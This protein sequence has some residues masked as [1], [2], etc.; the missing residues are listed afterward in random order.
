MENAIAGS[1]MR[2]AE[3]T[4]LLLLDEDTGYLIPL[5]EWKLACVLSGAVL[6]DLALENRIDTDLEKLVLIDGSHTGDELLDPFLGDIVFE[7][8]ARSPQYWVE[9]LAPRAEEIYEKTLERLAEKGILNFES[10]GFWTLA[11]KVGASG[12]YPV[13]EGAG[14]EEIKTRVTRILL[15]EDEIPDPRDVMIIG[16]VR[17]CGG[18][19]HFLDAEELE[20]VQERADLIK[21][22]D[23]I[24]QSISQAVDSIYKPPASLRVASRRPLPEMT[25]MDALGSKALRSGNSPVFFAEQSERLGPVFRLKVPGKNVVVFA[26]A[27]MNRWVNRRGRYYLRA[28]DYL[29]QFESVWGVA[30][31]IASMDGADHM[32]MRKAMRAGNSRHVVLDRLADVFALGRRSMGNWGVGNVVPGELMSQR[33]MGVQIAQLACSVD[34][35]EVV[36]DLLHYQSRALMTHIQGMMPKFMLRTPKM[37]RARRNIL[38]LFAE[39]HSSHTEAQRAGKRRDLIDD[40][41]EFHQSDPQ[42]LPETDIVFVFVAPLIAGHYM[43]SA[44]SFALYELLKNPDICEQVTAEADALF[45]N[46]DPTEAEF[47]KTAIDVSHRFVMETMR[48][49]PVI[50]MQLRKAMNTIEINGMEIPAGTTIYVCHTASHFNEEHF[51]NARTF[52]I[53]RY[54][55]DRAEHRTPGAFAPFGLGTHLCLGARFTELHLMANLL[56]IAHHLELEMVPSDYRLKLSPLPKLSPDKNFKFRVVRQRHPLH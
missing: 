11:S 36:D 33:L 1:T 23:L 18:F 5:P 37:L 47:K 12:Q 43:G 9:K 17:T 40:M 46:G 16:L 52:D 26:G 10:G 24:G 50:P 19:A 53:D 34:C 4:I 22:M 21:R 39:I 54:L 15:N 25:L 27:E 29:S 38:E 32:R 3:E 56:M 44:I 6:M 2:L 49:H 41:L 14:V 31:S 20:R 48:L 51:K 35:H 55:P 13:S 28:R 8:E 7:T 45:A 42:F 30:R